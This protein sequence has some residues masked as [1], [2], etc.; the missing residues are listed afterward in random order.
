MNRLI[1]IIPVVFKQ[2][3]RSPVRSGLTILGI[4]VAMYLFVV[5][6]AMRDGVRD[7][8]EVQ[9]GDTTLVVYRENRFCPFSSKLPQFY[10]DRIDRIDGVLGVVPMQIHF[11][12]VVPPSM[13]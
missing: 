11:P 13:S 10:E 3:S 2:I 9:A 1:R 7:A 12:I 8:T 4:A 5:V 6:E